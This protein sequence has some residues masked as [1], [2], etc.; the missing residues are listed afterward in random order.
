MKILGVMK[1]SQGDLPIDR[2]HLIEVTHQDIQGEGVLGVI[3]DEEGDRI[4]GGR[5]GGKGE[6]LAHKVGAQYQD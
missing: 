6:V 5:T 3:V 1:P 4:V 2:D